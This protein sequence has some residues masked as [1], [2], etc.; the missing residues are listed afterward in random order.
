MKLS[1]TYR[2]CLRLAL[3]FLWIVPI[4]SATSCVRDRFDEPQSAKGDSISLTAREA[5]PLGSKSNSSHMELIFSKDSTDIYMEVTESD[6]SEIMMPWDPQTKGSPVESAIGEFHVSAYLSSDLSEPY[7]K[8][9]TLN[10][11]DGKA[12]GTG[13]YWPVSTPETRITFFGYAKNLETGEIPDRTYDPE[14]LSGK[15]SYTLPVETYEEGKRTDAVPQPDLLFAIAPEKKKA[16]GAVDMNFHHA[17]SAIVFKVGDIPADFRVESVK[18]TGLPDRGEC[19][20]ALT[21][22]DM[23]F[24]WDT[25]GSPKRDFTQ[26]FEAKMFDEETGAALTNTVVGGPEKTFMMIPC[27]M[28][29]GSELVVTVGFEKDGAENTSYEISTDLNKFLDSWAPGRLYT[30]KISSP[31][32]IKVAIDDD[33]VDNGSRKENLTIQ[34]TG[35]ATSYMR[36]M[37]TGYWVKVDDDGNDVI[38][39]QWKQPAIGEPEDTAD[40]SFIIPADFESNWIIGS[41]G[42]YYYRHPVAAGDYTEKLFESYSLT[43]DAPSVNAELVFSIAVQA[44]KADRIDDTGWPVALDSDETTLIEAS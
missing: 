11:P 20:F 27:E 42:F 18:F 35:L 8:D 5:K 40:G 14:L 21:E 38:I 22:G 25:D 34:N 6:M 36:V 4:V 17:L 37:P 30:Y 23:A 33:V 15:F 19:E 24:E 39:A 3:A 26:T 1:C 43:G 28:P 32:E 12:V 44:V 10:S 29:E 16:D 9:I 31:E 13:Y 41:D 7:F 2:H